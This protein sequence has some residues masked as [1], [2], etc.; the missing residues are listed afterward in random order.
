MVAINLGSNG[1]ADSECLPAMEGNAS[2]GIRLGG[3]GQIAG[4]QRYRF[5]GNFCAE[6]RMEYVRPLSNGRGVDE[7]VWP[8]S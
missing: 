7:T 2:G 8:G 1:R 6:C 5:A 4:R 3:S